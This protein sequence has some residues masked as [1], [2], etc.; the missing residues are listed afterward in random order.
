MVSVRSVPNFNLNPMYFLYT[1][2]NM[3]IDIG[4]CHHLSYTNSCPF[5]QK[6]PGVGMRVCF[7]S[8]HSYY[9]Q[10]RIQTWQLSSDLAL[11]V[12]WKPELASAFFDGKWNFSVCVVVKERPLTGR[13]RSCARSGA[14]KEGL[15]GDNGGLMKGDWR[16][17]LG[18]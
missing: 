5:S 14:V 12:M 4:K 8:V 17:G 15:R 1:Y 11:R 6:S 3:A 2:Y 10:T 18:K 7:G 9:I 16:A 13:D